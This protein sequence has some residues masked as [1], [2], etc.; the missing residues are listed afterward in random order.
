MKTVFTY[1][2]L[3]LIPSVLWAQPIE[4]HGGFYY[5]GQPLQM[6]NCDPTNVDAGSGGANVNWDFTALS[7]I[8]PM[9]IETFSADTS[10]M[11]LTS[12]LMVTLQDGTKLHEQQNSTDTYIDGKEDASGTVT[13]YRGNVESRRPLTYGTSYLD[14]FYKT[15][16]SSG[17]HGVGYWTLVGDGYGTL[18]LPIGTFTNVLRVRKHINEIDTLGPTS[19]PV[20]TNKFTTSYFWF[21]TGHNS[22]LL[23]IDSVN[24]ATSPQSVT[25]RY[26]YGPTAIGNLNGNMI[27]FTANLREN[28][29]A[30][31]GKFD[32]G[33]VYD[34]TLYNIIGTEVF[35]D[36]FSTSASEYRFDIARSIPDG[37]YIVSLEEVNAPSSKTVIKVIKQ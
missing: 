36:K 11:F 26:I 33:A 3:S 17:E 28:Q 31:R 18:K 20:I 29:L 2:L 5:I 8:G 35:K 23:R 1:F 22:P 9:Y 25:V 19:A 21:D 24:S 10:S 27:N 14:T 13:Y 4:N 32:A 6:I 37:I 30:L 34:V 7:N 12:N 16:P 15:V